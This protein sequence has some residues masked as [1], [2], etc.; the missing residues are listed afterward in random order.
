MTGQGWDQAEFSCGRCGEHITATTEEEYL[1]RVLAHRTAHD[2]LDASSPE[3]RAR[4]LDLALA[5]VERV[6]T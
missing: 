6:L 1:T 4:L 3:L 5:E 2:L